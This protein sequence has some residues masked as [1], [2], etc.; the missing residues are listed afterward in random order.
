MTHLSLIS[1]EIDHVT[2]V[3]R[4]A[5]T[6]SEGLPKPTSEAHG[7]AAHFTSCAQ[8]L[9]GCSQYPLVLFVCVL[10]WEAAGRKLGAAS[11][12]SLPVKFACYMCACL[13]CH[14]EPE[15]CQR[16][17]I[18]GRCAHSLFMPSCLPFIKTWFLLATLLLLP[19]I[20]L[21]QPQPSSVI[22]SKQA[23]VP[24]HTQAFCLSIA[25]L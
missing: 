23:A 1:Y 5:G 16:L 9:P 11:P 20:S 17:Q 12:S 21:P 18:D 4:S 22:Y 13:W 25:S 6:L 7:G 14:P 3:L 19:P 24:G 8:N 10:E 15:A 2:D